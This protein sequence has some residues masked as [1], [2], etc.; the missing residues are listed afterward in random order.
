LL[1]LTLGF[2]LVNLYRFRNLHVSDI[3][4]RVRAISIFFV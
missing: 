4:I 1:Y 2:L 3:R